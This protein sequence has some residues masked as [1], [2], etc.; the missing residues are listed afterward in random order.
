MTR[1]R[2]A[3]VGAAVCAL[4]LPVAGC[5]TLT[6]SDD[7]SGPSATKGDDVTIGL[8][9]PEQETG[10]YEKFDHPVI[11]SQIASLTHDKG[12]LVYANAKGSAPKQ[13][14]QLDNMVADKVD[15]IIVDAVN[16]KTI[17]SSIKKAKDAGIPVIAY[18][19]LADGPVDSYVT[20]D[21][22]QV[23]Q[24][25]GQELL[26]GIGGKADKDTNVV[27][28]NGSPDDPNTALFKDGALTELRGHVKIARSY[29]I[30]GWKPQTAAAKIKEA[31]DAL[32]ADK[33]AGVY[34]ANDGMAGGIIQAL[35]DAGVTDLPPVTG[36]DAELAAVQRIVAGDQYMSVYK[37]Y[38]E[39]AATA[40]EMAVKVS[41]GRMIEYEALALDKTDSAT[42]HDIRTHLIP[43]QALTRKTIKSTVIADK[44]YKVGDICT[45]DYVAACKSIGLT[46]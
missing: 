21:G 26:E 12:T 9:L 22:Q 45:G 31:V 7:D 24:V 18:D 46:D 34:S 32:G 38:P 33:I 19:R 30:Q 43:V 1:I 16:Y 42:K 20:F 36:Q 6:G 37:P 8:L 17:A 4:T 29:D 28:M 5:G 27:M 14:A 35:K 23:G 44:I 3:A 13:N 2:G 15:A 39:E 41:Q 11:K 10:R 40:A 25:Q